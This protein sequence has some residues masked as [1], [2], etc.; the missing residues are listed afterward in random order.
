MTHG[1]RPQHGSE[2][3]AWIR[4]YVANRL[5]SLRALLEVVG[6]PEA[7]TAEIRGRIAEAKALLKHLEEEKVNER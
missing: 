4:S 6:T 7:R 1:R 5:E 2:E 3:D